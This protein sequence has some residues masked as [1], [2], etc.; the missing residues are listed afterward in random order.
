M[1][2]FMLDQVDRERVLEDGLKRARLASRP[3]LEAETLLWCT[4]RVVAALVRIAER[5]S[6]VHDRLGALGTPASGE[7]APARR[8]AER[9][10]LTLGEAALA[11]GASRNALLRAIARGEFPATRVGRAWMVPTLELEA[12]LS[13][14]SRSRRRRP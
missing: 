1:T 9:L 10:T 5:L 4:E 2:G 6:M 14:T 8:P 7:A 3:A 11:V 12:W 13:R